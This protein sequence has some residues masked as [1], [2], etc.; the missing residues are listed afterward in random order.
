MALTV[1]NITDDQVSNITDDQGSYITD[2]QASYI[3]E[4][5]DSENSSSLSS[6]SQAPKRGKEKAKEKRPKRKANDDKDNIYKLLR[7]SVDNQTRNNEIMVEAASELKT[8]M[9]EQATVLVNGFKDVMKSL[10]ENK[11]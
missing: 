1:S 3:T 11:K 9:I 8:G 5:I 7:L 2:D 6:S 10:L 4:V